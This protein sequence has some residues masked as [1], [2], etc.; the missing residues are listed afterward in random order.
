MCAPVIDN[1]VGC[2]DILARASAVRLYASGQYFWQ[3]DSLR[4]TLFK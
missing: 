3:F 2:I 1:I 4:L